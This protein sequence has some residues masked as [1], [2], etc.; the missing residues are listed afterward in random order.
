MRGE[1]I[2]LV[3]LR[4]LVRH[5]QVQP[6]ALAL[7]ERVVGHVAEHVGAEPPHAGAVLVAHQQLVVLGLVEQLLPGLDEKGELLEVETPLR[8]DRRP[9]HELA[10]GGRE[11]VDAGRDH[12]LHGGGQQP[13]AGRRPPRRQVSLLPAQHAHDLDDEERVAPGVLGDALCVVVTQAAGLHRELGGVAERERLDP[14]GHVV[15]DAAGPARALLQELPPCD[16]EHHQRDL[17]G[18]LDELFDQVE[19]DGVGLLHVLEDQHHRPS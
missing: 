14:Q 10:R 16:A 9:A 8:E 6:L 12:G 4:Q 18:L 13:S 2:G 5:A 19:E 11:L 15:G 3:A 7:G 1:A 17:P